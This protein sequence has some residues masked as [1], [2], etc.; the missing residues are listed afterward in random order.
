MM[1]LETSNQ[2]EIENVTLAYPAYTEQEA[3]KVAEEACQYKLF[4]KTPVPFFDP[5]N[6]KFTQ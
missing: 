5:I 3:L 1:K 4:N 2:Q 6:S